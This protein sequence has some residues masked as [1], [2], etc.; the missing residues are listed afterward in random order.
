M[1][2][3]IN[4]EMQAFQIDEIAEAVIDNVD[5]PTPVD[6]PVT[7]SSFLTNKT[8]PKF[9][10]GE[11]IYGRTS[12]AVA[13]VQSIDINSRIGTFDAQFLFN[14]FNQLFKIQGNLTAGTFINDEEVFQVD[15]I[16]NTETTARIHSSTED[17]LN[18]TRVTGDFVTVDGGTAVITGRTSGA[19]F[20]SD[21]SVESADILDLTYGD[22]DPNEGSIIYI[23]ND[24]PITREENQSEEIRVILEF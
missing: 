1:E 8:V 12:R 22:L 11:E 24:V 6:T 15:P 17:L 7:Y 5:P 19:T 16:N 20:E 4:Y 3:G 9:E 13:N 14:D 23:Q 21:I 2:E 10:I 18:L